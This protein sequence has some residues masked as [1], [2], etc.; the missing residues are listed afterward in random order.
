MSETRITV[1]QA[2]DKPNYQKTAAELLK[3]CRE[4]YQ[5]PENERAFLEW[6]AGKDKKC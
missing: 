3:R 2:K 6:K 1:S 4:F 5:N